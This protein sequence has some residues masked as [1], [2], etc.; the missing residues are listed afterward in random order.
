M[1]HPHPGLEFIAVGH[2]Y[3]PTSAIRNINFH[4]GA[5]DVVCLLGPS[6]C[7]KTTVL[8]LAAGLETLEK[9][10]IIINGTTVADADIGTQSPPEHRNTGLMF[11]DFALFPHL[12]IMDNILFGLRKPDQQHINLIK[13]RMA[14]MGVENLASKYPHMLSG[15]QQQRVALLRALA[16]KPQVM[17]LDEPFSGLDADLRAQI[18]EDTLRV[19]KDSGVA[20]LMVTHD[21]EEAMY[22]ADHM[23][24]MHAG[25][26][27]QGGSP[28][29]IY[30]HPVNDYVATLFG[31][32]N[33]LQG[34]IENGHLRTALGDFPVNGAAASRT[35]GRLLIRQEG[36][37]ILTA[38]PDHLPTG[39]ILSVRP[40]GRD[41]QI[42]IA[43]DDAT[44]PCFEIRALVRGL[45]TMREGT[46]VRLQ[47]D[48]DQSFVFAD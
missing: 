4:I 31:P 46:K 11:Q 12:S 33:R 13:R 3:G 38:G 8:R 34:R 44:G 16:P 22:M 29:Q 30:H 17:L 36:I 41:N 20:T 7:G 28:T 42:R 26:I 18:R 5:G 1:N 14:L 25:K 23:L 43:A 19:L 37:S 27:V 48:P 9:G 47:I 40:L 45:F 15:G 24:V 10:R 6:G 39:H 32:V 2:R 21:P 35:E